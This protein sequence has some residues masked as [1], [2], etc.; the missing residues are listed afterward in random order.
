MAYIGR[1]IKNVF[2]RSASPPRIF[3]TSGFKALNHVEKLEEENWDWYKPGVFY[4]VRIGEVFHSRYQV[5]GKLGYGSRST[6]WLCRDLRGH[7]Y[8]TLKICDQHSPTVHRELAAY[9]HLDTITTSNP[10]ALLVRELLDS[11]KATGP[12]GEHQC[13]V[14]EPLGMSI[15]TLRQLSPGQKLPENVLKAFLIHLLQA[16]DFLHTEAKMIHADLQARNVHLRIEDDSILKQFEA[17]ELSSPSPRKVYG[18]RIIYESRGL[19]RPK[20]PGRP[21]LCDFGEARFGK[22]TYTDD[23]QPYVYRAPEIILDIPWTYSVDIWN[24][25]V[26]IWD[27]FENKHLFNAQ[28]GEGEGS[29]LHHMAEMVAVLGPPPLDYL[30][31]TK[32]SQEYFDNTGNW[33]GAIEVPDISLEDSEEQLRGGKQLLFLDFMRK[34]LQ[35]VPEKRPTAKQL[36]N[37]PWLSE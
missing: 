22:E 7:K 33:Q 9:S 23:I 29:S 26:M 18:D 6:A 21:V 37:H 28:D 3:P 10:G 30:Q 20:A 35:W 32:I 15:E 16:L 24:V 31:R 2:T 1:W 27:I 14:H 11:F 36:L 25:G 4:P 12:A 5:L 19:K 17:A 8:V 34:M 13:L